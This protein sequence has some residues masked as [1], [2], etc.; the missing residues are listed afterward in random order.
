MAIYLAIRRYNKETSDKLSI[1]P[2][3]GAQRGR[4]RCDFVLKNSDGEVELS[5]EHENTKKKI[6]SNY[7][8]LIKRRW[9]KNRLL[10][11]YVYRKK[12]K[13]KEI[14]KLKDFKEEHNI[15]NDVHILIA[16]KSDRDF[17]NESNDYKEDII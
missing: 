15:K 10:I 3:H 2:E 11:C 4:K 16:Q 14:N 6:L 12:D 13:S 1:I 7:L 9:D 8:K 17:F 5:I